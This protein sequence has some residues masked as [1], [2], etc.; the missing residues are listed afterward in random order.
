MAEEPNAFDDGGGTTPRTTPAVVVPAPCDPIGAQQEEPNEDDDLD[1]DI[2][3]DQ[4]INTSFGDGDFMP[5]VEEAYQ[6]YEDARDQADPAEKPT[7]AVRLFP[8]SQEMSPA[9]CAFTEPQADA[10]KRSILSPTT[11]RKVATEQ[12][13]AGDCLK[14]EKK[15]GRK[16]K[17]AASS[18]QPSMPLRAQDGPPR[19]KDL[20]YDIHVAG[21]P[22]LPKN[23]LETATSDKSSVHYSILTLE[24]ILL[25]EKHPS[26]PVFM[27]KVPL[28]MGFITSVPADMIILRF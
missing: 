24:N 6:N 7:C 13:K 16:R 27:A 3:A 20:M 19:P 23:M 15:K 25:Q 5:P 18:S 28:N 9:A 21:R 1:D 4:F 26:Y 2:Q 10:A 14:P 8:S 12:I 11:L 17:K 22:M